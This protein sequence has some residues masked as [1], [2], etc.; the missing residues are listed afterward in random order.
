MFVGTSQKMGLIRQRLDFNQSDG[1]DDGNNSIGAESSLAEMDSPVQSPRH[2]SNFNQDVCNGTMKTATAEDRVEHWDEGFGCLFPQK[3]TGTD[4]MSGSPSPRKGARPY[5]NSSSPEFSYNQEDGSSP[6]P[7]CPDTPPH[8]TF[9]KL[10]LF[11]V[12]HTPK[13][14]Y[15]NMLFFSNDST[16][17]TI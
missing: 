16:R 8:K 7:G 12:P 2:N 5:Y 9:R 14:I 11:D 3:S 13:V 15:S 10:R 4:L 6:I 17:A 1:E